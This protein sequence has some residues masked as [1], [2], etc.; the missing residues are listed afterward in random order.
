M[1]SKGNPGC[2][3]PTID[4][5]IT[6]CTFDSSRMDSPC[7]SLNCIK[8]PDSTTCKEFILDYCSKSDVESNKDAGCFVD[9]PNIGYDDCNTINVQTSPCFSFEC[10]IDETSLNCLNDRNTFCSDVNNNIPTDKGNG[11]DCNINIKELN[12]NADPDIN[13]IFRVTCMS[14]CTY[15]KNRIWGTNIYSGNSGICHAAKTFWFR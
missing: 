6:K 3:K 1:I 10:A 15:N 11:V 5:T 13:D 14:S 4:Y 9:I 8:T 12:G 2:F 7:H